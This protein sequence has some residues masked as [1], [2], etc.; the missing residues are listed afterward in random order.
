MYMGVFILQCIL[1][2]CL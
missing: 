2:I 1:H